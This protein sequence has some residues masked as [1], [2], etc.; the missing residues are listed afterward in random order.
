M[1]EKV[2]T[3]LIVSKGGNT[4][5]KSDPVG[6]KKYNMDNQDWYVENAM[7]QVKLLF[8]KHLK[9]IYEKFLTL[10]G[11]DKGFLDRGDIPYLL[12]LLKKDEE[13][14]E[15]RKMVEDCVRN[16]DKDNNHEIN[17]EE[18]ATWWLSGQKGPKD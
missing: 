7:E 14:K 2:Q 16:I 6:W 4:I 15:K 1:F 3:K 8:D 10:G 5:Y 17:F 9:Y 13:S 12:K 11:K 18:F